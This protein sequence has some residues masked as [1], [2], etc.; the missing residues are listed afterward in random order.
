MQKMKRGGGREGCMSGSVYL[1]YIPLA[2]VF[3]SKVIRGM[4]NNDSAIFHTLNTRAPKDL[5]AKL[6]YRVIQMHG[7]PDIRRIVPGCT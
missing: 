1:S 4:P 6:T 5:C 7:M 3:Y 2:A